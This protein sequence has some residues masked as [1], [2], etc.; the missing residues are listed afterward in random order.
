MQRTI[1]ESVFPH[2]EDQGFSPG[3]QHAHRAAAALADRF[4][5]PTIIALTDA[6]AFTT[7]IGGQLHAVTLREWVDAQGNLVPEDEPGHWSTM[8][9]RFLYETRD[10][11][12]VAAKPPK[13]ILGVHVEEF[14]QPPTPIENDEGSD[15]PETEPEQTPA[16]VEE[17]PAAAA[18]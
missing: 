9:I 5:A 16:E 18:G 7:R 2:N 8:A 15:Q 17:Q 13:E 12:I 4:D 6:M 11:K 10:G 14:D 1:S 3:D